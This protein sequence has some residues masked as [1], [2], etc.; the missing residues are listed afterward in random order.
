MGTLIRSAKYWIKKLG[1]EPHPEGGYFRQTYKS[2]LMVS[3]EARPD[4]GSGLTRSDGSPSQNL[5]S[6]IAKGAILE[7]GTQAKDLRRSVRRR[8]A[9][10]L[11]RE[12]HRLRSIR[13]HALSAA[14]RWRDRARQRR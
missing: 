12:V 14:H 5:H 6:K 13:R 1:L 10:I 2:E 4:T 9:A 3:P 7:W 8:V 11:S